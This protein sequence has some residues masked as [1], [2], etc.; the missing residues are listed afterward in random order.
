MINKYIGEVSAAEF[1]GSGTV[2]RLDMDGLAKLESE[3]GEFTWAQKL[4]TGLSMVSPS[5]ILAVLNVGLRNN[6]GTLFSLGGSLP[7]WPG[8]RPL[9]PLAEKCQDA[10]TLFMYGKTFAE[11]SNRDREEEETEEA[12]PPNGDAVL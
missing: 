12:D 4:I 10:L 3:F 2:I 1:G 5:K 6:K 9:A 7:E 8:D 11:W